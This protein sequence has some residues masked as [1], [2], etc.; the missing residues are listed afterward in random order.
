MSA[1]LLDR[2]AQLRDRTLRRR[3][4][5]RSS[6]LVARGVP[7]ASVMFGSFL[8][9]VLWV[10]SAPILPACGL[11]VLIAWRQMRPGLLPVWAGLPLGAFDDLYSGQP[12]GSAVLLWS[13][14][15]LLLETIEARFPWRGFR[16]EW[17]V[18]ALLIAATLLLGIFIANTAGG[19]TPIWVVAPQVALSIL[20]Y[21]LVARLVAAL[22]RFRLTPFVDVGEWG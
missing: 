16:T 5:R 9:A 22:D 11:L 3:I 19:A 20:C 17:L 4:N 12:F 1:E 14:V 2:L 13:L 7:W 21:P 15:M 6:E 8:P 18:A 10:A